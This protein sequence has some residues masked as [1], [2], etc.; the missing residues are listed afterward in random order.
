M[1]TY[2][3]SISQLDRRTSD[4]FVIT[5][6]WRCDAV[7]GDFSASVYAT[8]SWNGEP[9]VAYE[10]LTEADVLAWVWESVDK[11]AAEQSLAGQIELQK[12]PVQVSGLPWLSAE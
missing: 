2:N 8:C 12:N 10:N 11:D 9:E 4:D 7:D 5:A 3:W 1:T 6:H